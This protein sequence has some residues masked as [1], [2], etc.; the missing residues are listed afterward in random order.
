MPKKGHNFRLLCWVFLSHF[1]YTQLYLEFVRE[2]ALRC[3]PYLLIYAARHTKT[4][5]KDVLSVTNLIMSG[6]VP[7]ITHCQKNTKITSL[8]R[9]NATTPASSFCS[10]STKNVNALPRHSPASD[11]P[12]ISSFAGR[13]SSPQHQERI[14][15]WVPPHNMAIK[16]LTPW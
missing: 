2:L 5:Q 6:Y 13:F 10:A 1:K 9:T 8:V 12:M 3:H 15:P 16:L 11:I 4:L 14:T 7:T